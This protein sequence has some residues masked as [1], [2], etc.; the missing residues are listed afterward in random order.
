M[1]VKLALI[2]KNMLNIFFFNYGC[3]WKKNWLQLWPFHKKVDVLLPE[4]WIICFKVYVSTNSFRGH[5][6]MR[7]V[8]I[9]T[10][11]VLYAKILTCWFWFCNLLFYFYLGRNWDN[12][13]WPKCPKPGVYF[14]PN[15]SPKFQKTSGIDDEENI[16]IQ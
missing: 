11:D 2:V 15:F 13:I 9:S 16:K 12:S 1:C 10:S 3:V 14:F 4:S 8:I 7:I 6:L 5:T